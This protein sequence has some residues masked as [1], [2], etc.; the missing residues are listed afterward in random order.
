MERLC[1]AILLTSLLST[2]GQTVPAEPKRAAAPHKIELVDFAPELAKV[3]DDLKQKFAG[4]HSDGT[5]FDDNLQSI[6]SLILQHFKDGNREQVARL[7]LLDA[8]IYADGLTNTA[9]ARAIW[10]T[11]LRDFP[12]T[13]A[14]QGA[15]ISL[16][17]LDAQEAEAD[18]PRPCT[19]HRPAGPGNWRHRRL[20]PGDSSPV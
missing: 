12:G 10:K 20:L 16:A 13:L 18:G 17:K 6:K 15:G 7:Y 3:T 9:K 19:R 11:V 14:A 2:Y 4:P 8:H 1:F 5:N